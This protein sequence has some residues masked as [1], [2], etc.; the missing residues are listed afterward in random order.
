MKPYLT[1]QKFRQMGF[2]IDMDSLTDD[3]LDILCQRAT[4]MVDAYCHV[5][6]LPQPHDFRGGSVTGEQ[7]TWRYPVGPTDIGQRKLWPFHWPVKAVSDFRIKVTN[8]QYVSIAAS[9]LFINNTQRYVEIVSLAITSHGLFQALVVPNIGLATPV[10]EI[11]YTYGFVFSETDERLQFTDGRT[12]RAAHQWWVEDDDE[13]PVVKKNGVV[14]SSGYAVDYD[15]G[16]VVF[17]DD[18][19]DVDVV[20]ATYQRTL[21]HEIRD[22]TGQVAAALRGEEENR[23]RGIGNLQRISVE[24]VTLERRRQR[25]KQESGFDLETLSP[26]A[27]FL[28]S[29][30]RFDGAVIR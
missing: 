7:H 25:D 21:P 13:P 28:L 3:R 10:A 20:T 29:T 6:R 24:E 19:V 11:A 17:D 27:A 4:A 15:E 14:Q 5:P 18:L 2:G 8:T 12:W 30:Y 23:E 16:A 9:E 1:A 26:E 22:A